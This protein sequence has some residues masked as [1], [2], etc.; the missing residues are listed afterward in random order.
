MVLMHFNV[1]T[2]ANFITVPQ[3]LALLRVRNTR[4]CACHQ[5]SICA[6]RFSPIFTLQTKAAKW[7]KTN[8]TYNTNRVDVVSDG[9][10]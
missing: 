7:K 2:H 1:Q 8:Y 6:N 5:C 9:S 3:K 10:V 4:A